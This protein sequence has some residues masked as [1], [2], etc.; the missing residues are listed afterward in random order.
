MARQLGF[1]CMMLCRT[2]IRRPEGYDIRAWAAAQPRWSYPVLGRRDCATLVSPTGAPPPATVPAIRERRRRGRC[3]CIPVIAIAQQEE[4]RIVGGAG[5]RSSCI[6]ACGAAAWTPGRRLAGVLDS[7]EPWQR[8]LAKPVL[9]SSGSLRTARSI[10]STIGW[11][12]PVK[13]VRVQFCDDRTCSR[14]LDV[15]GEQAGPGHSGDDG[16]RGRNRGRGRA[17]SQLRSGN[18]PRA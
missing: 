14:E 3:S 5:R 12:W 16:T 11:R 15:A 4:S 18:R 13:R 7:C 8:A 2:Q 17:R 10:S 9:R 6:G 1:C